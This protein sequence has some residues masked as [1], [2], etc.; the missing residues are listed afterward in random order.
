[1]S[2]ADEATK[3]AGG[4]ARLRTRKL[5]TT[6]YHLRAVDPEEEA[7]ARAAVAEAR[8][9]LTATAYRHDEDAAAAIEQAEADLAAA[10][11]KL[12]ACYEPVTISAVPPA[13]FERLAADHPTREGKDEP[14]DMPA[15]AEALFIAG[16]QGD[17]T[18]EQWREEVFPQLTNGERTGITTAALLVNSRGIGGGIPKD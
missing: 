6:V 4:P 18:T 16:V 11:E 9:A 10:Q 13:E 2:S 5:A 7:A 15:L 8:E 3:A 17:L 12:A 14:Y 1:M